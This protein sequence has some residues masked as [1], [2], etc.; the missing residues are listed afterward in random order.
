MPRELY[1]RQRIQQERSKREA[2]ESAMKEDLFGAAMA[3]GI[4]ST[5]IRR[6]FAEW[7]ERVRKASEEDRVRRDALRKE[8]M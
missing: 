3:V 2:L 5:D 7:D 6:M 8:M 4:L 1:L